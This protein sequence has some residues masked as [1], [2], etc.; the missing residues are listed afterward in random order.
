LR[1]WPLWLPALYITAVHTVIHVES[2]YSLPTRPGLI[3]LAATAAAAL[4]RQRLPR[5]RTLTPAEGL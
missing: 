5:A 3:V 4:G 2:R 1:D